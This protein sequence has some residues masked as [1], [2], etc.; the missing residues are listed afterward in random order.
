[1]PPSIVKHPP[2]IH[3]G[4]RAPAGAAV[5]RHPRGLRAATSS[6]SARCSTPG[7]RSCRGPR[8]T[9]VATRR[10]MEWLIFEEEYYRAG[11]P[12]RV[13]QN[14]IFLLAPTLFEFGTAGAAGPH[15]ARGWRRPRTCGAR[16]GP[17]PTRAATSPASSSR[18]VRDE[19]RRRL[20]ADR[21]RRP[22]RPAARSA[23]TCS[24]CSAPIPTPSA[25]AASPTSSSP[26]DADGRHRARLRPPRR[27]RGLRR[28]VPRRRVRARRRRARRG[29]PGLGGGDGDHRRPSAGSRCAA[30]AGSW[31]RPTRLVDLVPRATAPTRDPTLRDDVVA[32]VDRRR[33]VP[34]VHAARR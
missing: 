16:A 22:G 23:P 14:G 5:G 12:Q 30:R 33:G 18:A 20:A 17:S 8:S 21:A 1:M 31:R 9:A 11:G 3:E 24:A 6:G 34:A 32:G 19:A 29:R 27:R 10:L 2:V 7:G 4:Q 13:T 28:G 26:L 15:P 25:T